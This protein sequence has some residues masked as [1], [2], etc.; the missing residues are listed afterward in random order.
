MGDVTSSRGTQSVPS[1]LAHTS[2][3]RLLGIH[4]PQL[5]ATERAR[6]PADVSEVAMFQGT[7]QVGKGGE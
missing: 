3:A 5:E 2:S 7:R 1:N 6:Q 4:I